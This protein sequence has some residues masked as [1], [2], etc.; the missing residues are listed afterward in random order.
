LWNNTQ[1]CTAFHDATTI[2]IPASA[3]VPVGTD[4]MTWLK[5]QIWVASPTLEAQLLAYIAAWG[6]DPPDTVAIDRMT[7]RI[8]RI[9][10]HS[11]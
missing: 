11:A 3:D 5:S 6:Q 9:C 4:T 10:K 1:A 8:T 2:G 7:R